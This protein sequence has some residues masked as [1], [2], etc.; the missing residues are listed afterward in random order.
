MAL[1]A[2][3][4]DS[5]IF[6]WKRDPDFDALVEF[7]R[8]PMRQAIATSASPGYLESYTSIPAREAPLVREL[9]IMMRRL[10]EIVVARLQSVTDD[11]VQEMPLRLIPTFFR[12]Y[13]DGLN[14]L[15]EIHDRESGYDLVVA[16]LGKLIEEKPDDNIQN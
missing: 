12:A 14:L 1:A 8:E 13:V 11:D 7:Y 10:S 2:G 6:R 5:T 9:E 15:Q 3:V 16:E 4:S